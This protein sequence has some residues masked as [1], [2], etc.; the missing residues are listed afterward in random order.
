MTRSRSD[1]RNARDTISA[2][3][4]RR[5]CSFGLRV[6]HKSGAPNFVC[7]PRIVAPL[8][9]RS[10]PSRGYSRGAQSVSCEVDFDGPLYVLVDRHNAVCLCDNLRSKGKRWATA[11]AGV[12]CLTVATLKASSEASPRRR[13][14]SSAKC[15]WPLSSPQLWPRI[16]PLVAIFSPRWWPRISPPTGNEGFGFQARGLTPL[17]A[18]ACASR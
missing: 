11:A 15:Q 8:A 17:P 1:D 9:P 6:S 14:R 5:G 18:V 7:G 4:W 13:P 2:P 12:V 3:S 10:N 16:S